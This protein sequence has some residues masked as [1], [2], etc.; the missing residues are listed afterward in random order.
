MGLVL[1][2]CESGAPPGLRL[3]DWA[4]HTALSEVPSRGLGFTRVYSTPDS[5]SWEPQGPC[6][7]SLASD[8]INEARQPCMQGTLWSF[9]ALCLQPGSCLSLRAAAPSLGL[10]QRQI[11]N[12]VSARA[13]EEGGRG[14]GSER[15]SRACLTYYSFTLKQNKIIGL[16][17]SLRTPRLS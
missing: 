1:P 6:S 15:R 4:P 10:M 7:R 11:M 13:G 2:G 9:T 3:P 8:G 5:R 14:G 12:S 17:G 16:P